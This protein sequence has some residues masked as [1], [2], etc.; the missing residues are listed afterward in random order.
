MD[1]QRLG[2]R[3]QPPHQGE[4]TDELLQGL[5]LSAAEIDELRTLKAVA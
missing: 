4:N 3:R 5:G 1:G 2:V